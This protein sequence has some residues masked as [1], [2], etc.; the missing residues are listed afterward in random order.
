MSSLKARLTQI[1]KK[2][3]RQRPPRRE[4]SKCLGCGNITETVGRRCILC[5]FRKVGF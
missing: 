4:F 2:L 3:V 5:N 1:V